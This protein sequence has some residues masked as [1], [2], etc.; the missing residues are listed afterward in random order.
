MLD[1]DFD[2]SE[3]QRLLRQTT[4]EFAK[5]EIRPV[6]AEMEKNPDP[7]KCI[8]YDLIKKGNELGFSTLFVP[9]AYGGHGASDLEYGIWME[10]IAWGDAGMSLTYAAHNLLVHLLNHLGTEEHKQKWFGRI[11]SDP[12][13]M[14]CTS[15]T[16]PGVQHD[17]SPDAIKLSHQGKVD[18]V[19]FLF[20][21]QTVPM[22]KRREVE[23]EARLEG[24]NYI[25]NGR[26]CFNTNAG[27]ADLYVVQAATD[28]EKGDMLGSDWFLAPAGTP[29]LSTGRIED[30]V[31]CRCSQQAETIWDNVSIPKENM[32]INRSMNPMNLTTGENAVGI[33]VARAAFEHAL[34]YAQTRYKG[35]NRIIFHQAVTMKLVDMLTKIT[36]GRLLLRKAAQH[37]DLTQ[38]QVN[39]HL[40]ALT[41]AVCSDIAMEVT[42]DAI[43]VFGGYGLM[44]D[45]PLEKYFRDAKVLQIQHGSNPTVY[46]EHVL[47]TIIG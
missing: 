41:K 9:E 39:T 29:G 46:A 19:D 35:G 1:M 31:G 34:E 32:L 2:L 14:T 40:P 36:M 20:T 4:H 42:T 38:Y 11:C 5:N 24:D 44:K 45:F 22:F 33:G 26:K 18:A 8:P 37:N 15:F 13:Y 43:Q 47:P 12:E 30:K 16:E 17:L 27:L 28:R 10:E 21:Q 25:I 3:E 7:A 23:T 6:A